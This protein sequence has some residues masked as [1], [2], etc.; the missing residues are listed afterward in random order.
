MELQVPRLLRYEVGLNIL[1]GDICWTNG[2]YAPGRYN[3]LQ[4]FEDDLIHWLDDGER[5]EADDGYRGQAPLKVKC[6]GMIGADPEKRM[7]K[8]RL[9]ARHETCNKRFKQWGILSQ[10]YRHDFVDHHY[11]FH[12]IAVLTQ[13]AFE[14]GEPLF[15]VE[16][17]D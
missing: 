2:P 14:T 8:T 6:P 7:M 4:I 15:S 13:L 12:A 3:D 9:R 1:T 5:V 17:D 11:V 16:Y 10:V